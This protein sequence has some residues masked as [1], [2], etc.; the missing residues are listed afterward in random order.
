MYLVGVALDLRKTQQEG[1]IWKQ[2]AP[3]LIYLEKS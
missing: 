1:T 3:N 2:G